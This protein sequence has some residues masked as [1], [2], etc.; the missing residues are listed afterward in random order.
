MLIMGD[1]IGVI[2]GTGIGGQ[3]DILLALLKGGY[4]AKSVGQMW[5][6]DHYVHLDGRYVISGSPGSVHGNAFGEGGN[7]LAGNG[8]LLVSDFAY[9][10][11]HIRMKLPENP[12]YAQIQE[13]IMEEGRVY[14]P[15][16]RIHVAPTGM[17]HGGR[18]H[19]HIDMFALLLPIRKLLLLD[20]YYGK[21]AGK[22]AEY[23][24]IAEAEG[25]KL[26]RYDGSQD[27]VWYPLNSLV[28]SPNK[29]PTDC[30]V[31]DQEAK[32]LIKILKDEGAQVI[33]ADMPQGSYP[34]GKINCQ[35]NIHYLKDNPDEF[36]GAL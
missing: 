32:S 16:V 31:L 11:Q 13:V 7:I 35:T 8:F 5:P 34:D 19:G 4:P 21:G 17:F 14:H 27:G 28:L 36:M 23:D 9:K 1:G 20:T 12:N 30:V 29:N 24:S 6:R 26:R 10:H 15:H 18:G 2:V 33:E 25:L 22:A 3:T